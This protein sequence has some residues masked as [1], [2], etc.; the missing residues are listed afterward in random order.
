MKRIRRTNQF[1][2]LYKERIAFVGAALIDHFHGE[3]RELRYAAPW[4]LLGSA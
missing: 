4:P 2:R 1:K 3:L